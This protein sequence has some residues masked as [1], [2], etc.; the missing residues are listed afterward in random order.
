VYRPLMS[1][2]GSTN[3]TAVTITRDVLGLGLLL[4]GITA[5]ARLPRLTNQYRG[6]F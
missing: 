1:V 3:M 4:L 2:I 5:A 6:G